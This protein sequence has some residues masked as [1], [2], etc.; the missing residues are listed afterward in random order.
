MKIELTEQQ[1]VI[2]ANMVAQGNSPNSIS[3]HITSLKKIF[4]QEKL[5][6]LIKNDNGKL[7]IKDGVSRGRDRSEVR[8][9]Q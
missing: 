6:E 7:E 1:F 2:L 5:Q 4:N 9:N 3:E 8:S